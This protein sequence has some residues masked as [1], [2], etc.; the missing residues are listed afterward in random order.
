MQ[1]ILS[2]HNVKIINSG[3]LT[4]AEIMSKN[5]FKKSYSTLYYYSELSLEINISASEVD[6]FQNHF[7][8]SWNEILE[9]QRLYTSKETREEFDVNESTLYLLCER[10]T[11]QYLK[12]RRGLFISVIDDSCTDDPSLKK[13][14]KIPI[15]VLN[16]FCMYLKRTY[17]QCPK[18]INYISVEW[19]GNRWS[20]LE[21]IDTVIGG[22]DPTTAIE[23]SIRGFI[24]KNREN[25]GLT[26][27]N[28]YNN[29]VHVSASAFEGL[30]DRMIW[31]KNSI[32]YTD[33]FGSRLI[34]AKVPSQVIQKWLN[35][36]LVDQ[37]NVLITMFGMTSYD[38][39]EIAVSL[40]GKTNYYYY[41]III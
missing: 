10:S 40:F 32:L 27:L 33:L 6:L 19:D 36:P 37:T 31:I 38:C 25:L 26:K 15:F 5:I 23:T 1:K 29:V 24:Y 28:H 22:Q 20:W 21:F 41:Y 2:T 13:K 35:N 12:I 18:N 14:L 9:Q 39:I 30:Y 7:S 11:K 17:E 34:S 16:G 8:I 3:W 4:S